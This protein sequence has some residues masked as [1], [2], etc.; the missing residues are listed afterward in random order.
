M[1][2]VPRGRLLDWQRGE[3]GVSGTLWLRWL[4]QWVGIDLFY[5]ADN[6]QYDFSDAFRFAFDHEREQLRCGL[7]EEL[8][9]YFPHALMQPETET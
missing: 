5:D 1:T 6:Q 9:R 3:D 4:A 7:L 2:S 8:E